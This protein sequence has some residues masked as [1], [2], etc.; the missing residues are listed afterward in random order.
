MRHAMAP[1]SIE[2][3]GLRNP[4]GESPAQV[5]SEDSDTCNHPQVLRP[6]AVRPPHGVGVGTGRGDHDLNVLSSVTQVRPE[7]SRRATD[8]WRLAN[9]IAFR[10]QRIS[11]GL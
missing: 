11:L 3:G 5:L 7:C 6:F 8:R 4:T 1:A 2:E 10:P 9:S